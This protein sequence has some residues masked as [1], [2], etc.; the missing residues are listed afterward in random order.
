M[1]GACFVLG[2]GF[3]IWILS[4]FWLVFCWLV[5]PVSLGF[6]VLQLLF[7]RIGVSFNAC[8]CRFAILAALWFALLEGLLYD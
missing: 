4:G 5:I 6:A 7:L 8:V 3:W 1:F 2:L